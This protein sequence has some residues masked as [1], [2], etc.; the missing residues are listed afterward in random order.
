MNV[1]DAP[2]AGDELD[3]TDSSFELFEDARC[4]TDS[5][6][7]RASGNAVLDANDGA[8]SHERM[9]LTR[10]RVRGVELSVSASVSTSIPSASTVRAWWAYTGT[11]TTNVE[12]RPGSDLTSSVPP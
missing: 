7:P 4:Q 1:E 8:V 3:G 5:V 12:P 11:V 6:R 10:Y 2:R 9:L